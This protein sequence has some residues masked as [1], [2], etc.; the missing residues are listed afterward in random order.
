MSSHV[1]NCERLEI[2]YRGIS[3]QKDKLTLYQV[4]L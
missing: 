1:E 4:K 2:K 3:W